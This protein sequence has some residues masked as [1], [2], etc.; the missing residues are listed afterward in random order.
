[1]VLRGPV[2]KAQLVGELAQARALLYRG[3]IGE[4]FCSAVA[5][6]QAMGVPA[7]LGDIA[8]MSERVIEGETGYCVSGEDAFAEAA[9]R[10][11]NDD[12]LWSRLHQTALDRQRAWRWD[13][14][15]Q[16]FERLGGL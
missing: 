14:A 7:V 12:A 2:P 11:M 10:V 4:T 8:C 13:D 9:L 1:V 15:A 16:A 5:E 6:A 3:D